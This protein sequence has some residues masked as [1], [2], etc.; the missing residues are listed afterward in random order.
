MEVVRLSSQKRSAKPGKG[1]TTP[2]EPVLSAQQKR[3]NTIEA[4]KQREAE[5]A[6]AIL[7]QGRREPRPKSQVAEKGKSDH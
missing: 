5:E 6:I 4:R 1:T 7:S 2:S 3:S